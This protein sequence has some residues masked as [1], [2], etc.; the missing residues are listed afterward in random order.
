MFD[1]KSDENTLGDFRKE[2]DRL[3]GQMY[4]VIKAEVEAMRRLWDEAKDTF[5]PELI[6]PVEQRLEL[7]ESYANSPLAGA[8]I[9]TQELAPALT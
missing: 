9:T 5:P 1:P 2:S 4:Q 8:I 7:A 6:D 3:C